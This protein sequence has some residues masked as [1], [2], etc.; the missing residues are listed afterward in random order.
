ML[1]GNGRGLLGLETPKSAVSQEWM[2]E[3]SWFFHADTNIEK[4][5]VLGKIWFLRYG[6][7]CCQP[8]RL[9]DFLINCI[10]RT[11]WWKG[12]I[13]CMLIQVHGKWKLIEKYWGGHGQ[14]WAWPLCSH[15]SKIGFMSRKN[16]WNK[17]IFGVLIQIHES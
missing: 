13:F 5:R 10:S 3:M 16:E 17:F 8:I 1:V 12:L 11:K 2:D 6:P 14:K 9:Q 7:K 15:D 4:L